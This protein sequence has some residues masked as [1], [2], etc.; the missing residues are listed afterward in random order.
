[1]NQQVSLHVA[2]QNTTFADADFQYLPKL[3]RKTTVAPMDRW[4]TCAKTSPRPRGRGSLEAGCFAGDK[5][6]KPWSNN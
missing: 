3:P 5:N 2:K 4:A 6:D 1:M